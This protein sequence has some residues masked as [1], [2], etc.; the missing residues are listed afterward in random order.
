MASTK[1]ATLN[2]V[3]IA[4]FALVTSLVLAACTGGREYANKEVN[5]NTASTGV[6][7]KTAS[8]E[9]FTYSVQVDKVIYDFD[10]YSE[11]E[12]ILE[13]GDDEQFV[14]VDISAM[15]NTTEDGVFNYTMLFLDKGD[16]KEYKATTILTKNDFSLDSLFA[17][18][19][20]VFVVPSDW[21]KED[22]QLVIGDG[23]IDNKEIKEY[24]R[25]NLSEGEKEGPSQNSENIIEGKT[26]KYTSFDK[27]MDVIVKKVVE[28]V[29]NGKD[30]FSNAQILGI[31]VEITNPGTS[32]VFMLS[33]NFGLMSD[34]WKTSTFT[35]IES[36]IPNATN[37]LVSETVEPGATITRTIYFETYAGDANYSL[38]VGGVELPL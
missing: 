35:T 11:D 5:Y 29:D 10:L 16:S 3:T 21:T 20:V 12:D 15:K 2:I 33:S 4:T 18:G 28:N 27:E 23:G 22:I 30:L 7:D 26:I 1:K 37:T 6:L 19:S 14:K 32:S 13:I 34:N 8:G 38:I 24:A 31:E 36:N 25:I 9:D 17:T